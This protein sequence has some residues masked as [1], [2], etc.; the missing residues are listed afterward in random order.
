MRVAVASILLRMGLQPLTSG[1]RTFLEITATARQ[2]C[3]V[4]SGRLPD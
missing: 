1:W 2:G 4:C 3:S